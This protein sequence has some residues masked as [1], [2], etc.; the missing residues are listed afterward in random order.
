ME[1]LDFFHLAED[2]CFQ[3]QTAVS[4]VKV[5]I[6]TH[7]MVHEQSGNGNFVQNYAQMVISILEHLQSLSVCSCS[8][9][10]TCELNK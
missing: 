3:I 2:P 4:L 7:V 1:L 9:K 8:S 10:Q 5:K 6:K